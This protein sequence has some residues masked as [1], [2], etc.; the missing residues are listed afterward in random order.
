M[1]DKG[2]QRKCPR[3]KKLKIRHEKLNAVLDLGLDPGLGNKIKMFYENYWILA[4]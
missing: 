2:R 1:K 3:L 4:N